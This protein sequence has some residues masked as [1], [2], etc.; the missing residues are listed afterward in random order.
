[1]EAATVWAAHYSPQVNIPS[2]DCF[3]MAVPRI[4][5]TQDAPTITMG[6]TRLAGT[7]PIPSDA[8]LPYPLKACTAIDTPT[9]LALLGWSTESVTESFAWGF[10]AV[11]LV[12][13]LGYAISA[14]RKVI[15]II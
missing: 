14:A 5:G 11:M 8:T 12:W 6:F 13:G 10:G 2:T 15:R 9:S 7:C 3:V 4:T 1:M